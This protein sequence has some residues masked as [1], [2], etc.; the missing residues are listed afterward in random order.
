MSKKAS[1]HPRVLQQK[2][3]CASLALLLGG[4]LGLGYSTT[5]S[6]AAPCLD[7]VTANVV[8]IDQPLM[9][10]RLGAQNINGMMYALERDVVPKPGGRW[11]LRPDKRPRPLV[12]RVAAGDCLQ[13]NL[14][15]RLTATANPNNH[16]NPN[17]QIDDQVK[18]RTIGF[19][20]QGLELANDIS[21]DSS[22]VGK[23]ASSLITPGQSATYT[24]YAKAEGAF[25][26]TS[27]GATIGSEGTGGNISSG[28]W[29]V[30]NVQPKG[31]RFYRS[32]MTQEELALATTGTSPDGQPI[33]DYE[34]EYPNTPPWTDEGK[35]GLPIINM[36]TPAGELIHS[37]IDA[38]IAGP[39]SD[40]SFPP[41]TYPLESVGK[42]NPTVPNRLEAFRE[43]TVAFH[44][45]QVT[46]QA[47]PK[48]F[49]DPV[50]SHTLHGV[51]DSFMINYGSGGIGSEII[52]NR[53]G[54][55]PMYD[56]LGCA[57][58]EFF[59]TAFTVGDVGQV[60]DIP[61]NAGLEACTPALQNC[62]AVGPKATKALYPSDPSN[63][64]HSYQ[65]DFVKFRQLHAGPKEQHIFHLHNHQWLFDANDDNANYIDAQGIGPGSGYTLEIAFGGA[66]N[67][68]KTAGDAIFHC[69]FYPHFAQ[70]MWE[71][72]RIHDTFEEGT[73]LAVSNGG[74]HS[75]PWALADGTPAPGARAL[76]DGE[77]AAGT[78]IPAVVPLPGKAMA[79]MPGEVT[80]VAQDK[81]GPAGVPDGIPDNSQALVIDRTKNPGYPFWIAGIEEIVG[82]RPPTPPLD[83]DV[84]AGGWDGGLPRHSI[85]GYAEG[86]E[87]VMPAPNRLDFSKEVVKAKP[88]YYPEAGTDLEQVAMAFH[89]QR[90]HPSWKLDMAS[91]ISAADYLTNGAP[92]TPGAPYNEPCVDDQGDLLL[93]GQ[94]GDFFDGGSGTSFAG[95][96]L[97]GADAPRIYKGANVQIDAV[98]NKTGYHFPQQRIITLWEDVMPTINKVRPPE[99][100]VIRLN[101]FDCAMYQH[102]NLV[103]KEYELDDYQVRTP[104]DIIG[105]HIHLPKWDLTTADGAAN[106]WN[107]EDG[108]LSPGMVVERI[109]A[110]NHFNADP[111]NTPI[112]LDVEGNSVA[113]SAGETIGEELHPLDH[114]YFGQFGRDDWEGARTTLQRWFADPVFNADGVDRGLGIIFTHDHY[115]P[116]THQQVGLYATVL[117]EP[118]GSS[119]KHNETGEPLYTRADGGPTSWQAIIDTNGDIDGDGEDDSYREFYFEFAD[120][121]HAYQP[122]VYIGAGPD[123]VPNHVAPTATSYLDSINPSIKEEIEGQIYPDVFHYPPTCP[124]GVPRPCPEAISAEDP[125]M[126]VVNY[127]AE[128]VG[129]RVYDPNKTGPDGKPGTQADGLAGDLAFAFASQY[130]EKGEA[131]QPITRK[132]SAL[133]TKFGNTPYAGNT[134]NVDT[135][136]E[137]DALLDGD[138]FT[139]MMRAYA[140]DVVRVKMQS[141]AH[142]EEH[143]AF[144]HGVKWLQSG[145]GFG[146]AKNSGWRNSQAM[147]ISEQVTFRMPMN[148][149][150]GGKKGPGNEAP[151]FSDHLYST[152]TGMDGWW[153]GV[154]GLLRMYI[155]FQGDDPGEGLLETLPQNDNPKPGRIV[156]RQ[157]FDNS[158]CPVAAPLREYTL[159]A[160]AA[161]DVLGQPAGVTLV[162]NDG[163]GTLHEGAIPDPNGGTLVYN[164]RATALS[165]LHD[166]TGLMYVLAEDL[167]PVPGQSGNACADKPNLPGVANPQCAVQ[168]K[169]GVKTEP[170]VLRAAAGDCIDVTLY[171]RLPEV[172]YDL[173]S[174]NTFMGVV[175]RDRDPVEGMTTFHNNL[176]RPSS[177]VGLHPQL[178]E[179]DITQHD[180]AN[181][182]ANLVQTVGPPQLENGKL[183]AQKAITYR[184][185][186]GD[187]QQVPSGPG[188]GV[189]IVATPI[190]FGGSN[191]IPADKLKQGQKGLMG[192]LIVEPQGS[193]W[194][195]DAGTR[196]SATVTKANGDTFRD[197][198]VV[199]QKGQSH[200]YKDGTAI[201]NLEGGAAGIAEDSQDMGQMAINY[202]SEPLWLRFGLKPSAPFGNAGAPQSFGSVPNAHEAYS[203][204]LVGNQDPVTPVFTVKPG[205]EARM[206]VLMPHGIGRGSTFNVHGHPWQRAPYVCEGSAKH[207]L[208]GKCNFNEVGSTSIGHNP[209]GM[210]LGHQ[211]SVN[212]TEH[213]EVVLPSAGGSGGVEGDYL[214]R[215]Q[216][217][218]GNMSGVWGILRV[219]PQSP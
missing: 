209:A 92:A 151:P 24:F 204:S 208:P 41:S 131:P 84:T 147:G 13:V 68:N 120:F 30:V 118:A 112:V 17:L 96:P 179:Y 172:N 127:R 156:N 164:P 48:W 188:N 203:N 213:Y 169:A 134:P 20:P 216:A 219:D 77:I 78:P 8:A 158:V 218:F 211:E 39:N 130:Q 54:V 15:N 157:D 215:D 62:E 26:V 35:A 98:L 28:L 102:T 108:T 47:F 116:S 200:R 185:Y 100:F 184:W 194:A 123:G 181:I 70:G 59:L 52:S 199:I 160:V 40:G 107:Y 55:G 174:L 61:A 5:A 143:N 152:H 18:D 217:S 45:E 138:P 201:E 195:T 173:A 187:L 146:Q 43:F 206:R 117:V 129:L 63:V 94:R 165:P 182:G 189:E 137:P 99:P 80:V 121:Q 163:S 83:M 101:S 67:R 42:R 37:D 105:Q 22:F 161:N 81:W 140:G 12:L 110:I 31:A 178:V 25:L 142:E 104:T 190:E 76:P 71:M 19:H 74:I 214:F 46:A 171:N 106:G 57:Y 72:W 103:P 191:L 136:N 93:T 124:G 162:A 192:A 2:K 128:P 198:A 9:F 135:L 205:D 86:G 58:E 111:A 14:T 65:S 73:E 139:P 91:N 168:L 34:A 79:P 90:Q 33:I 29:G 126:L 109:E 183:K 122:G 87:H 132:I 210:Y 176:V 149:D 197:F 144:L 113:N 36:V 133:N 89:A 167:E 196:T 49:D 207:G 21:D 180:G 175:P 150:L 148:F 159:I 202:G 125:G 3:L 193:S 153:S 27:Y 154:W 170:P 95:Y 145:S 82:Q 115:G 56:C 50:L 177:H 155:E 51:R 1:E 69:H 60:V 4:G 38:I 85:G 97:F 11:E 212:G 141:G 66:G 23:N 16:P 186:A 114:P 166:P 10:N 6:A 75:T 119:W 32:I 88:Y 7:T 44:D 64:H 53:L